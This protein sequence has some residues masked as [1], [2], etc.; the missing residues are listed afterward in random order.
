M[1]LSR[2]LLRL[3]GLRLRRQRT[4]G[5][6]VDHRHRCAVHIADNR[7]TDG[8]NKQQARQNPR[9]LGQKIART[10]RRHKARRTAAHAERAAFGTLQQHN[11][12]QGDGDDDDGDEQD[13]LEHGV[14]HVGA[15][16]RRSSGGLY[17]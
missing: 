9:H 3:L 6:G 4:D 5:V 17:H 7:Q 15:D 2:L 13:G 11:T 1:W 14:I 16:V 10:T 12:R 8:Q